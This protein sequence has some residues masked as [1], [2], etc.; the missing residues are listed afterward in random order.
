M[1][2]IKIG[3]KEAT[4]Q[5]NSWINQKPLVGWSVI[6]AFALWM[7]ESVSE[8]N[9]VVRGAPYRMVSLSGN[10]HVII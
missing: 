7:Q 5:G 3:K 1:V 4:F 2:I 9:T 10:I 6:A 8:L